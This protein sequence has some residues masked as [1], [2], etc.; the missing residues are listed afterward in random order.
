MVRGGVKSKER[1]NKNK[2]KKQE[3]MAYMNLLGG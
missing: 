1:K 3:E 2:K